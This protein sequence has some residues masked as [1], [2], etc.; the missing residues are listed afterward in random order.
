MPSPTAPLREHSSLSYDA[1][2]ALRRRGDTRS[3]RSASDDFPFA[4]PLVKNGDRWRFD[5]QAGRNELLARRIGAKRAQRD[6][7]AAGDRRRAAR[8]RVRRPQR[9]RRARV[10]EQVHEQPRQARRP[11][12]ADQGRASRRARSGRWWPRPR[13]RATATSKRDRPPYHGYLLPNAEGSGS[14]PPTPARSTT[15]FAA[16]PSAASP[17]SRIRP[18][19]AV[20]GS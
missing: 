12:L 19:M 10:R 9:R 2:H 18:S 5:T 3:S 20:P 1:K 14:R 4:F 13:A 7:G 8:V 16:A 6:Q 15:S 17:S 11:V